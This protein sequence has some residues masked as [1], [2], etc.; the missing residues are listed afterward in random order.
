MV[1]KE[2]RDT[3][4]TD[5]TTAAVSDKRGHGPCDMKGLKGCV[6]ANGLNS[7]GSAVFNTFP[8]SCFGQNNGVIQLT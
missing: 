7:I 3:W 8:N 1:I 5:R 6:R 2:E 4:G